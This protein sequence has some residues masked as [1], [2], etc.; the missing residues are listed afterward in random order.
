MNIMKI[1][2]QNI[3]Q[4]HICCSLGNDSKSKKRAQTKKEWL[5][6]RF[7]NGLVFKKFNERGKM[8][9]EYMP[10]EKVWK[11]IKGENF[12]VIN[13]L[14]VSGKYKSRGLGR[15]LLGE[16]IYDAKDQKKDGIVVVTSTKSKPFLTEREFFKEFGFE[17]VDTAPPYFELMVLKLN[18][19]A[20][21]PIFSGNAKRGICA[22]KNGFTF[23]YSNQC[24]FIEDS[25]KN[26][27]KVLKN[28]KF[29]YDVIKLQNYKDAQ[30]IGSPFGTL[31]IYYNG[32]FITHEPMTE[33]K[34]EK[35][36]SKNVE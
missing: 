26:L 6:E 19:N 35:F 22:N 15:Q 7:N 25:I 12:L 5:K 34:F 4:E 20:K 11:P 31:G 13:C 14:W 16:I 8:F 32:K 23:I 1:N 29:S 10:I 9:I 21:S 30:Q 3:D 36:L 2:K 27:T 17:T 28:K 24:P 33:K 18:K